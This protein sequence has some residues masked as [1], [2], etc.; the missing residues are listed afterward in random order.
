DRKGT[1]DIILRQPGESGAAFG[2]K[3]N[4]HDR[5]IGLRIKTLP[6][7]GEL[8]ARNTAQ[9]LH[10]NIRQA[11]WVVGIREYLAA[12]G[13]TSFGYSL[14][15]SFKIDELELQL[16]SLAEQFFQSFGIFQ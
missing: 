2:I 12:N 13:R 5:S 7:I 14:G 1:T 15:I 6:R 4:V 3:C 8:V 9:T 11:G 16:R 10:R